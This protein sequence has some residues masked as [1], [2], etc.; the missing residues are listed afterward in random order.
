MLLT[1]LSLFHLAAGFLAATSGTP[2]SIGR[3][4][5][6][7]AAPPLR[8]RSAGDHP[9]HTIG[10]LQRIFGTVALSFNQWWICVGFAATLVVVEEL[11]KLVIRR[12]R[13]GAGRRRPAR[14]SP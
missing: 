1:T 6:I 3:R 7:H 12:R 9:G 11:I 2:S 14:P 13:A 5:G 8:D 10:F 4:A